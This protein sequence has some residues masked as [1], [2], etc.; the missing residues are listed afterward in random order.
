LQPVRRSP[1]EVRELVEDVGDDRRLERLVSGVESRATLVGRFS[2]QTSTREGDTI[3]VALD[4]RSL[5]FFDPGTGLAIC[6]TER[7]L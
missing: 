2:P 3:E 5:H 6:N 1:A 7:E 4:E